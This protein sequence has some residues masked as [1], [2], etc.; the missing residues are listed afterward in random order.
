MD[1]ELARMNRLVGDLLT[2]ARLEAGL[3][4]HIQPLPTAPLLEGLIEQTRL[5][6]RRFGR[7]L[8]IGGEPQNGEADTLTVLADS[9]RLHQILLNLLHNAVKFTPDGGRITIGAAYRNGK[10]ALSVADTG[11]GIAEEE[12]S[13]LFERFYRGDKAR[14]RGGDA[15]AGGAGL[16]LAIAQGLAQTQ[17]GHIEVASTVGAGSIFTVILPAAPSAG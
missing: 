6:A 8:V 17:G 1:G 15:E 14:A 13:L 11:P 4:I 9:D 2:L 16:G 10:I 12:L 7:D 3:P 5:L